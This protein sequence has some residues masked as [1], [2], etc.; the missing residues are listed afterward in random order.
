MYLPPAF[1][2]DRLDVLHEVVRIHPLGT[3]VTAG[4]SDLCANVLPFSLHVT[5]EGDMLRAHLARANPQV[6]DL[7]KV[8]SCLV[9]FQ[10]PQAYV[11]P[12]WYETKR[13]HGRVVPTWNYVVVQARGTPRIID[14][15]QW[16]R[17]QLAA[18]T[19]AH[20]DGRSDPWRIEDA[21]ADYIA[22]QLKGIVGLEIRVDRLEGKW[23]V[24]QNQPARNRI[25]VA[26]GLMEDGQALLAQEVSGSN[27]R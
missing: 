3:L 2:E 18:M 9:L 16:L 5:P 17:A 10:G 21:P 11:T 23:K 7:A 8:A 24:S 19:S 27:D 25:G 4:L 14:D 26:A 15:V 22:A 6:K 1:R 13:E 12:S 20:E